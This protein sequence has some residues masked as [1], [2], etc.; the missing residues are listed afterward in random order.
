[1]ELKERTGNKR[2]VEVKTWHYY[3]G[4]Q[5]NEQKLFEEFLRLVFAQSRLPESLPQ[6]EGVAGANLSFAS[7]EGEKCVTLLL[8]Y[9]TF[10][11]LTTF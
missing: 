1:M 5:Q 8:K 7:K 2:A 9:S 10:T 4:D 3:P 11:V 6:K